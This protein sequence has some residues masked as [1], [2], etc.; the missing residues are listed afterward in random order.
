MRRAD[1]RFRTELEDK[2]QR[3]PNKFMRV[4]L[5]RL[6]AL[7]TLRTTPCTS[8][9]EQRRWMPAEVG[10]KWAEEGLPGSSW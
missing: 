4:Q 5:R 10:R 6:R 8:S 1:L 3:C 7:K 9:A 2:I